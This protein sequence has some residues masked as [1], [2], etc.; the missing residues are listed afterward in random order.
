MTKDLALLVGA[1]QNWLSTTGFLD[2]IDEN[3]EEGDGVSFTL[4][5][6]IEAGRSGPLF[7]GALIT[8]SGKNQ[9]PLLQPDVHWFTDPNFIK[10]QP[11][12]RQLCMKIARMANFNLT[13]CSL[14]VLFWLEVPVGS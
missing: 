1:D 2:K 9:R 10:R 3:L 6:K 7:F 4:G 14:Y 13:L 11:V 12:E 5:D 8:P